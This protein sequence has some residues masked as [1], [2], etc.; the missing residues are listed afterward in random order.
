MRLRWW[1]GVSP[2][3]TFLDSSTVIARSGATKQ[4]SWITTAR[5]AHLVMTIVYIIRA[6]GRS[7]WVE[8]FAGEASRDVASILKIVSILSLRFSDRSQA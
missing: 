5:F 4:S 8:E 2:I 6:I 3:P 1:S 7:R